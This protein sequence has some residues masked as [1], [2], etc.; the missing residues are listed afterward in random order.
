MLKDFSLQS[1]LMGLLTAF[2]GFSSSFAVVLQGIKATGATDQQ[3]ASGL[4]ALSVAMGVCGIVLSLWKRMPISIAWSTPGAA[5]LASVGSVQGGFPVAV[6]AFL[7]SALLIVA[8]GLFKPLNR[9]VS[10]IPPALA[11]AMLAGVLLSLCLAPVKAV[12]FNPWLGLPIVVAFFLA[13]A[14]NRLFAVPVALVAFVLVIAFGV[15]IE[16]A[17]LAHLGDSLVPAPALTMPAFTTAGLISIALPLFIITMASQN[18]PGITVLRVNGYDPVPGPL[19]TIT[20]LFSL[21]SA[22]FGGH[23]VNLAAI[24]AAMCAGE[25]AHRDPKRRYWSAVIGGVGYVVLGLL[26]GAV[27]AAVALAP[28]ILIESVAGLALIAAFSGSATYAFKDSETREAA[29][30]TFIVTASGVTFGGVSGAFWGLLAGGAVMALLSF[31]R[32]LKTTK[33]PSK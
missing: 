29:A 1:L 9:A 33:V 5:F 3:A 17:A 2:V 13:A 27:T 22:P 14:V 8:A 7:V 30:V 15:P 31:A 19:F 20:G 28:K 11:N 18:I 21:A 10:S 12:A 26:A 4:M 6:G 16:P 23:A 24:T 25:D 32:R